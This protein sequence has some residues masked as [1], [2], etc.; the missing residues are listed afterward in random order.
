MQNKGDCKQNV[1]TAY[2]MGENIYNWH[3]W[4]GVNLKYTAY[5]AQYQKKQLNKKFDISPKKTYK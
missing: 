2:E 4:Q 5:V 3:N 1:K